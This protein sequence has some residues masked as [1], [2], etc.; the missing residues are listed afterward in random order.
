MTSIQFVS[1]AQNGEDVVLARALGQLETG[2]YVEVGANDPEHESV[3]RA[4][5]DRGWSGIAI[6]PEPNFAQSF[7]ERRP[8]DTVVEAVVSDSGEREAVLHSFPG[9]G[10]STI[11][12]SISASHV[13]VGR[14]H[15][16]LRVKNLSLTEV[17]DLHTTPTTDIHFLLIDT[18]GAE[19]SV[20][21]S[22]DFERYRPWILV[23]ESTAPTTTRQVHHEWEP[24]VL[25][26]GYEFCLFDG[27]SRFYVAKEK[28]AEF[29][30]LLSYPVCIFDNYVTARQ[31]KQERAVEELDQLRAELDEVKANVSAEHTVIE[32]LREE[33]AEERRLRESLSWRVTRPLRIIR[34]W[35]RRFVS[36]S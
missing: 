6:E 33:L 26:A 25:E 8:R 28:S 1:H 7:R 23:I 19:A 22:M 17:L 2:M 35:Q 11:D 9:T 27:L 4:F 5:Y 30:D 29:K 12:N 3:S 31:L 10:L 13:A 20:I 32:Q 16:E 34:T 14:Q 18:E 15:A 24:M 36:R 21:R